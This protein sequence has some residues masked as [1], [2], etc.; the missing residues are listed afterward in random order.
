MEVIFHIIKTAD[1]K[2]QFIIGGLSIIVGE[3]IYYEG[4]NQ[5]ADPH[6]AIA[7]FTY[8]NQTYE[9]SNKEGY[10]TVED[11]YAHELKD[12]FHNCNLTGATIAA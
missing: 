6:S 4:R 7:Q 10:F 2:T 8:Q 5:I 11:W 12:K 3:F 1:N 9:C